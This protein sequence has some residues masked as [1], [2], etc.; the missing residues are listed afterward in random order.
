VL[1]AVSSIAVLI[2]FVHHVSSSIQVDQVIAA[3]FDELRAGVDRLFPDR[4]GEAEERPSQGLP[5]AFEREAQP[6]C[7]R[8]DGYLQAIDGEALL[9][10]AAREDLVV[11]LERRPGH[12][13]FTRSVL[14]RIWPAGRLDEVLERE[15]CSAFVL[16]AQRT[17]AQDV[18]FSVHQLVEIAV[19]ALSPGVNDPFTA[20]R[21]VDRLGS[22]LCRLAERAM[23][24][25]YRND[26]EGRLRVVAYPI[27]F[28]GLAAASFD[29]IRQNGRTHA[30][31][32]IRLL[33][34]IAAVA[35]CARRP[36]DLAA[37][38]VQAEMIERGSREGLTEERDRA[39]V[40]D[41]YRA[42]AGLL[43]EGEAPVFA[44]ASRRPA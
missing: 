33:E 29:Q 10:L 43:R 22:V 26:S 1:L 6:V 20:I 4:V 14:A 8:A 12:Y 3:V 32:T 24:S 37:L 9:A 5:E 16:G 15:I 25:P 44:G 28:A 35:A 39:D 13:V 42:V 31:V 7:A 41:R 34:V 30:A 18:E 21:C 11:R 17:P 2:Y 38:R 19:R 23:P 36:E 27:S 40:A